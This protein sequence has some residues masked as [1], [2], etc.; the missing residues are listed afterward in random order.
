M[1]VW[2]FHR[3]DLCDARTGHYADFRSQRTERTLYEC[4]IQY[5]FLLDVGCVCGF[6]LRSVRNNVALQMEYGR[7]Q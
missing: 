5:P 3:S 4:S 1:D 2:C 6:L 7:R